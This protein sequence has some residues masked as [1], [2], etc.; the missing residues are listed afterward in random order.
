MLG[1]FD[2]V[3]SKILGLITAQYHDAKKL[4]KYVDRFL[5][6]GGGADSPYL[7]EYLLRGIRDL[8][9]GAKLEVSFLQR[10]ASEIGVAVGGVLRTL[11]KR[12]GPKRIPCR[13]IGVLRHIPAD[14]PKQ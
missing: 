6:V 11:D 4:K 14:D 9:P 13:S 3:A 5:V 10:R 12:N 2:P 7:R 1:I 8:D